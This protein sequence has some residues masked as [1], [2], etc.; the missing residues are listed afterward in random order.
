[1][2]ENT[3]FELKC[4]QPIRIGQQ[5]RILATLLIF[6]L[7]KYLRLND[8]LLLLVITFFIF[9]LDSLDSEYLKSKKQKKCVET[10]FYQQYDKI[11]DLL[12][13]IYVLYVFKLD[14]LYS[15][16]CLF[17]ALGTIFFLITNESY[18]L[19]I[20]PD[21][22]KEY[23]V[24]R[25]LFP[26]ENKYLVYLFIYKYTFE[27]VWHGFINRP[28]RLMRIFPEKFVKNIYHAFGID[29]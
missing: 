22:M 9:F 10:L 24:Y 14:N 7:L 29:L 5:I 3:N 28:D 2:E 27:V 16:F 17:R 25:Y 23:L 19:M 8:K 21:F 12:T 4:K 20:T 15:V 18:Y 13:Y 1:M 11:I 26:T 6:P